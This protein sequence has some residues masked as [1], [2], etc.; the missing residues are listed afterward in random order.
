MH[1]IVLRATHTCASAGANPSIK[2]AKQERGGINFLSNGLK[3]AAVG[4]DGSLRRFNLRRGGGGA[5][6]VGVFVSLFLHRKSGAINKTNKKIIGKGSCTM[7][8]M[9]RSGKMAVS[10]CTGQQERQGRL[11]RSALR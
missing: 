8:A 1:L 10:L 11:V 3:E 4:F 6:R 9:G 2:V 7:L 5:G